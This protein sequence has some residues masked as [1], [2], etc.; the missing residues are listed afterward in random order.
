MKKYS[1]RWKGFNKSQKYIGLSYKDGFEDASEFARR[2]YYGGLNNAYTVGTFFDKTYD[3]DIKQA[4]TTAIYLLKDI[5]FNKKPEDITNINPEEI[6]VNDY[7]FVKANVYYPEDFNHPC[8]PVKSEIFQT[9]VFVREA[10]DVYLSAPEIWYAVNNGAKVKIKGGYRLAKKK[11]CTMKDLARHLITERNKLKG[12]PLKEQIQKLTNNMIY[13]HISKGVTMTSMSFV[14]GKITNEYY[15]ST[16]TSLV[17]VLLSQTMQLIEESETIT[18]NNIKGM[19][20]YTGLTI[21]N[22]KTKGIVYESVTDGLV[23]NL[24]EEKVNKIMKDNKDN[25]IISMFLQARTELGKKNLPYLKQNLSEARRELRKIDKRRRTEVTVLREKIEDLKHK[26]K[27]INDIYEEKHRQDIL[28]VGRTKNSIG[29]NFDKPENSIMMIANMNYPKQARYKAQQDIRLFV[30]HMILNRKNEELVSMYETIPRIK[31]I[32]INEKLDVSVNGKESQV[33][34][35]FDHKR[36][37]NNINDMKIKLITMSDRQMKNGKKEYIVYQ[38][39]TSPHKDLDEFENHR[40]LMKKSKMML[41]TKQ[42]FIDFYSKVEYR[43][44]EINIRS[45][46]NTLNAKQILILLKKGVLVDK[47]ERPG[48][49]LIKEVED[50]FG[51]KLSYNNDYAR[52]KNKRRLINFDFL[53]N[54]IK[55]LNLTKA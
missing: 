26:I 14:Y 51:V 3:M 55:A 42:D 34:L 21:T 25:P 20:M 8:L 7:A 16:L 44:S 32:I 5:N 46:I 22:K 47:E 19:K 39:T 17:R 49:E 40:D 35:E 43:E 31:K 12:E 15:A 29:I 23:T 54:D 9:T 48:T 10:T 45:D 41:T 30:L 1:G 37:I 27:T 36:I 28:Y 38:A 18:K 50:L 13:G 11:S 4:Y 52:A 6:K 33:N 53:M 2:S 24:T